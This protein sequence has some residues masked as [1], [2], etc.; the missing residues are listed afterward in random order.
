[1][2]HTDAR[3]HYESGVKART[4]DA[5]AAEKKSGLIGSVRLALVAVAI[6]SLGAVAWAHLAKNGPVWA[7]LTVSLL[8]FAVLVVVHGRVIREKDRAAA[9]LRFHERGLA[10]LNGTWKDLPFATEI[11]AA[12]NHPFAGDLD[13]FGKGSLYHFIDRTETRFGRT[14][15]ASWLRGGV[16]A[17]PEN[18]KARQDSV[19]E[20]TSRLEFRE[21]LFALGALLGEEKPDPV[22][23]ITWAEG[24]VPI[25]VPGFLAILTILLPMLTVLAIA[26]HS[27]LPRGVWLGMVI[28]Q[29]VVVAP[30]RNQ[31]RA[32][33]A[34]ASS[35]E[36]ALTAY[37]EM[38]QLIENEKFETTLNRSLAEKLKGSTEAMGGLR[39]LLAFVDARHNEVFRL[40]IA[41][42][43]LWD[44]NSAFALERW[45]KKHGKQVRAWLEALG[46]IEALSS[47]A[48]LAFDEPDFSFP[49]F[50]SVPRFNAKKLGHPLI[51]R[52]HRVANDVSLGDPNP[53]ALIVTGSNMSGKSTLLRAIGVNAALALSGA[54]VCADALEI[55]DCRVATSM[56]IS[57]SLEGGISH[58]YAE[59]QKLKLVIDLARGNKP[60]LFLLDEILHGTNTRERLIGARAV[61]RELVAAGAIGAISTHDLAI[62]DLE[63][64]LGS[65]V[66]NVHF[67]EQVEDEKMTFDYKLRDGV[68]QSSN[69]LRLMKIVGL[70]TGT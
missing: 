39:T 45:R 40:F 20:L 44:A 30:L 31:V 49:T 24:G 41:P 15:L 25:T 5:E 4:L 38:L 66:K 51:A 18:V 34:A 52:E 42:V 16:G 37:G 26:F 9:A 43:L 17:F 60:V 67:E 47:L 2:A 28:L 6:A 3:T 53:L 55:G 23:M 27:S 59:L 64:E 50:A 12:P 29:L 54:P 65:R 10:R 14:H 70:P 56:R 61:A 8:L 7:V 57:D 21:K 46:E 69:A 32:V 19:K 36:G 1:M 11:G 58:F 68:V 22:P 48:A 33:L 35:R 62:G 13:L 63:E